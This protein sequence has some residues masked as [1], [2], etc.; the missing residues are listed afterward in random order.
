MKIKVLFF[1]A[2]AD[3][4]GKR[5]VQLETSAETA[6]AALQEIIGAY[7]ALSKHR[8]LVAV[9]ENY[10]EPSAKLKDGDELA[11]FTPVSGG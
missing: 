11:I 2:T 5:E 1:G 9:N 6:G 8:L 3:A 4:A 10:V 7:P